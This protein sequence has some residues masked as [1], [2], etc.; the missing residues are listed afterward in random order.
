M[1]KNVIMLAYRVASEAHRG[2]YRKYNGGQQ[3]YILH[4][5]RVAGL[6]ASHPMSTEN[7]VAAAALHDTFEDSGYDEETLFEAGLYN[8]IPEYV[9]M[10]TNPSK[11]AK[12]KSRAERKAMDRDHLKSM[13]W[14]V[15][16]IKLADRLDNILD[17]NGCP[18]A[19]KE[20]DI[21]YRAETVL[22]YRVLAGTDVDLERRLVAA[23]ERVKL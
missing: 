9:R 20:F 18:D 7:M 11:Q 3:P 22:L 19:P 14:E 1:N 12:D 2:Q 17:M 21:L 8:P 6:V 4:P 5:Y 23:V 13:P 10:L 15:K 16:L